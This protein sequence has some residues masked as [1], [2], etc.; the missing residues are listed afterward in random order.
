MS[1]T[2]TLMKTYDTPQIAASTNSMGQ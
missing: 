1:S 2:A